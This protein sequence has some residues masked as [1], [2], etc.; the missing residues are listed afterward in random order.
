MWLPPAAVECGF[1]LQAE[2]STGR[3]GIGLRDLVGFDRSRLGRDLLLGLAL[4][5]VGLAL[6]LGGVYG[7]GWLVYGTLTPPYLFGALPLPAALY[8]VFVFPFIWGLTEQMTYNGYLAPRFR[9]WSLRNGDAAGHYSLRYADACNDGGLLDSRFFAGC[10][11]LRRRVSWCSSPQLT[12]R[13]VS[14]L[15]HIPLETPGEHRH[16][17]AH[18]NGVRCSGN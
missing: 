6:I 9:V 2:A 4:I 16:L 15:C 7:M 14:E 8:A 3:E 17:R 18:P 5:P 1:R 12:T 11:L 13:I 10:A